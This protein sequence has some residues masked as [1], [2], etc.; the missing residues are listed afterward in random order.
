MISGRGPLGSI[1]TMDLHKLPRALQRQLIEEE[2]RR[3]QEMMAQ[4]A[5]ASQQA[6][7]Q[8]QQAQG[9][10][11]T[12]QQEPTPTMNPQAAF[13]ERMFGGISQALDPRMGGAQIAENDIQQ[14]N[15]DM[16]QKQLQR[17]TIMEAQATRL[18]DRY[19]R[20]NQ[21]ETAHKW[22]TKSEEI[23]SR[24]QQ[25]ENESQWSD[26]DRQAAAQ[27]QQLDIQRRTYADSQD[28][29]KYSRHEAEVKFEVE[30]TAKL[31]DTL[32][33]TMN[34]LKDGKKQVPPMHAARYKALSAAY[35]KALAHFNT[36]SLRQSDGMDQ[37]R[38]A[39]QRG[40]PLERAL[41]FAETPEEA[42]QIRRVYSEAGN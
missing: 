9:A 13:A 41:K 39:R 40:V 11:Q 32:T 37:F 22:M 20:L 24:R 12:A 36:L 23:A 34:G 8:S 25:I 18:A 2:A 31:L 26:Q 15:Q 16:K 1:H 21:L 42:D 35:D 33:N 5:A 19:E 3:N 4:D 14:T 6:Q 29:R 10:L 30:K 28:E 17:L 7:A 27:A 38:Q